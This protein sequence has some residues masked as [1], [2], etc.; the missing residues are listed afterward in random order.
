MLNKTEWGVLTEACRLLGKQ[1]MARPGEYLAGFQAIKRVLAGEG[2]GENGMREGNGKAPGKGE[3]LT[4]RQLAQQVIRKMVSVPLANP[5]L[6]K[7]ASDA[8]L[9]RLYFSNVNKQ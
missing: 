7:E 6:E 5:V 4:D 9:S 2:N 3:R 8:G 1:A